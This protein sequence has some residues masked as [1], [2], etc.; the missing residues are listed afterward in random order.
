MA[1]AAQT[2]LPGDSLYPVKRAIEDT[3]TGLASGDTAKGARL[4]ANARGRLDEVDRARR[5]PTRVAGRG[6]R[7][8]R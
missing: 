4:L 1:V 5:A 7:P 6:G 2:A 3:R 8:T